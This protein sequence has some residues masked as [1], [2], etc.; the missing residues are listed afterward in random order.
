MADAGES[1][2]GE[3]GGFERLLTPS[4]ITAWLD[5][6]HYLTLKHEVEG[7]GRP[8]PGQPFGSFAYVTVLDGWAY[9]RWGATGMLLADAAT[10][11]AGVLAFSIWWID[12]KGRQFGT[13]FF[14]VFGANALFAY[15]FSEALVISW[16]NTTWTAADGSEWIDHGPGNAA[17]ARK[18]GRA[19]V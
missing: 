12:V 13:Y 19:H 5:C 10:G 4:K 7:G 17:H 9:E 6:A 15:V 14:R 18:I 3:P 16:F 2:T 11:A 1:M 8:K